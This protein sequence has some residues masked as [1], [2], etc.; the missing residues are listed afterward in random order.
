[1]TYIFIPTKTRSK[2]WVCGLSIVGYAGSNPGGGMNIR[3]L[4]V[5]CV[6]MYW[7]L[8]QADKSS[9]RVL[10]I[11]MCLDCDASTVTPSLYKKK[12]LAH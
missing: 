9:R 2:A 4:R 5:L 10:P 8:R 7:S 6:V 12:A 3:P 1:M 11:V